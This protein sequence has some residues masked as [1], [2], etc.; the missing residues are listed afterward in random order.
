MYMGAQQLAVWR[1]ITAADFVR[2]TSTL[3]TMPW[4][5][6]RL[7]EGGDVRNINLS[8][9]AVFSFCKSKSRAMARRATVPISRWALRNSLTNW[10]ERQKSE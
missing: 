1:E 5:T 7:R 2:G 3:P 8:P 9:R 6:Y 4:L 10:E